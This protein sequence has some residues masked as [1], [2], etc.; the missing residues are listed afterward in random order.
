MKTSDNFP[1]ADS[2][3]TATFVCVHVLNGE[4]PVLMVTHDDDGYWQFLCGGSH[5]EE[6]ARIVSLREAYELDT[7]TGILAGM[8]YGE[9][10]ERKDAGSEWVVK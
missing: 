2:P 4:K 9:T 8:G 3:D 5:T 7:S 10:A 6:D 1:F